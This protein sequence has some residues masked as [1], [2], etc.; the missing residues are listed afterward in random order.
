MNIKSQKCTGTLKVSENV[1][2]DIALNVI[3]ET[4][5]AVEYTPANPFSLCGQSGVSVRFVSG[6]AE[7]TVLVS[8]A[9][10]CSVENCAETIQEKIK[11]C[12]QDMTGVMV[13]KVNVRIVSLI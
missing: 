2:V 11:S 7:I 4:E 9:F 8:V 1:I 3:R 6:A 5:G 13:S 12:V 10:G